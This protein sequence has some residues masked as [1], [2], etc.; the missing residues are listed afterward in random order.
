MAKINQDGKT[1]SLSGLISEY[2]SEEKE[3]KSKQELIGG[4]KNAKYV[5]ARHYPNTECA[6]EIIDELIG[7]GANVEMQEGQTSF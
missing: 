7:L 6:K 2:E 4:K 5:A 3:M 1:Y